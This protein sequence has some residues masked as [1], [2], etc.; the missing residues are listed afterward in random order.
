MKTGERVKGTVRDS[1]VD[2]PEGTLERLYKIKSWLHGRLGTDTIRRAD[3]DLQEVLK[4]WQESGDTNG[5]IK[6]T[7]NILLAKVCSMVLNKVFCET[8]DILSYLFRGIK[9]CLR[10]L[11]SITWSQGIRYKV[12]IFVI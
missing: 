10:G 11:I 12:V 5:V 8:N 4:M 3:F 7:H 9:R 1:C 2:G 6:C